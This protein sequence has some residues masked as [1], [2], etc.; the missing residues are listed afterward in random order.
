MPFYNFYCPSCNAESSLSMSISQY[1]KYKLEKNL[2]KE[3]KEDF[4]V[5][6]IKKISGKIDRDKEYVISEA[7]EEAK[8]TIEKIRQG[9]QKTIQDI[10]GDRPNPYKS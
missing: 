4:L 10:Y 8:K 5:Q 2:C 1:T 6:R 9:D 7:K 3:C